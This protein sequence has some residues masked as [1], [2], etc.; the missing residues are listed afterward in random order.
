[1]TIENDSDVSMYEIKYRWIDRCYKVI[2]WMV[3]VGWFVGNL[4]LKQCGTV[5]K[6]KLTCGP[7]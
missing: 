2:V 3:M 6:P 5:K 7:D 4:F 1:M